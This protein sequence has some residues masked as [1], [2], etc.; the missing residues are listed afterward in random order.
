MKRQFE[1]GSLMEHLPVDVRDSV[2]HQAKE[3]G[4]DTDKLFLLRRG[5]GEKAKT[6]QLDVG[7]RAAV[8][9]VST[10]TLDRDQEI[11]L[12][13]GINIKEFM[14]YAHVLWGHN[15]SLPPTGSD[16]WLKADDFGLLAKTIY[17]DTGEGT[18][19]NVVWHLVQQ[20]HQK[21]SSIGFVP[22][23]FTQPGHND[24][25]RV[26]QKLEGMWPEIHAVKEKIKKIITKVILLEHSDVSVP[27]NVDSVVI[28]VAKN[29]GADDVVLKMLGL[30]EA[31]K[32]PK[33]KTAT[34]EEE[35]FKTGSILI[36]NG[37]E[38]VPKR[39]DREKQEFNCSC[40][41][42]GHKMVSDKHCNEIECPKC[43]GEM[44]RAER[45]GPGRG[46][47][48]T[49]EEL[50]YAIDHNGE[51][52]NEDKAVIPFKETAKAPSDQVW[53]GSNEVVDAD[54]K[55]LKEMCAWYDK[56]NAD[57]KGSYKLPH[58]KAIADHIVVWRGVSAAMGSLLGARGGVAI[59]AG[60]RQGVYD[61]LSKHYIQFDKK[62]P[63]LKEYVQGNLK[64]MF[65]E[66]YDVTE[67][68]THSTEE[69]K[70]SV[71]V[72]QPCVRTLEQTG[73][74][75][76]IAANAVKEAFDKMRGKV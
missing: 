46:I 57:M 74:L 62:P 15:Y 10:R 51:L 29:F 75:D 68:D 26:L 1:L 40:I 64:K 11:I 60:D 39:G 16:E 65:P 18:L 69:K 33:G 24:F 56:D 76:A 3:E 27:A 20:G 14:K 53:E 35:N 13:G 7:S 54:V 50:H 5:Y 47:T 73:D 70:P 66:L 34:E 12:P 49:E 52:P 37:M 9:Y 25:E 48:F 22:L 32:Q 36:I 61:H 71:R 28:D 6:N 17:A 38:Y 2:F 41:E 31:G 4:Q 67:D 45:P 63:E 72:V 43:G 19:A 23:T 42:C 58:H 55:D 59:P 8:R 30:E 21:A 44:R